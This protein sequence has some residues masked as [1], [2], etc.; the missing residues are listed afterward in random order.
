MVEIL[1]RFNMLECKVM[2]TPMDSNLK[3]AIC[4]RD[5]FKYLRIPIASFVSQLDTTKTNVA[6]LTS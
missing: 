5:M 1:K 2:A 6:A 4:Y 3:I